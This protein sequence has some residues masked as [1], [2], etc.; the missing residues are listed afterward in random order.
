MID[1]RWLGR[2]G[3]PNLRPGVS[4]EATVRGTGGRTAWLEGGGQEATPG[5]CAGLG[6]EAQ[7]ESK[8]SGK[9]REF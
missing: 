2:L 8:S 7:I 3:S 5:G 6:E 1:Q 9:S 4:R